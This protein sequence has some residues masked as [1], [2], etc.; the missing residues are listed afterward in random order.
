[1]YIWSNCRSK[2]C[3][4][5]LINNQASSHCYL[6]QHIL[7]RECAWAASTWHA[8]FENHSIVLRSARH[9]P[10]LMCTSCS[11][12]GASSATAGL[13]NIHQ[14]PKVANQHLTLACCICRGDSNAQHQWHLKWALP[15]RQHLQTTA[16]ALQSKRYTSDLLW[17]NTFGTPMKLCTKSDKKKMLERA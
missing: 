10:R 8:T 9:L 15:D 1:M 17:S 14:V 13:Y 7:P 3:A 2:C 4:N 12:D 5:F 16:C 6:H 11:V